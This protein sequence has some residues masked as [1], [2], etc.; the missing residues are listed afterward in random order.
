[1]S[2]GFNASNKTSRVVNLS[3]NDVFKI[4]SAAENALSCNM[5]I[6]KNS[7]ATKTDCIDVDMLSAVL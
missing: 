2:I 4:Y 5:D 1:M 3:I 7:I 6:K